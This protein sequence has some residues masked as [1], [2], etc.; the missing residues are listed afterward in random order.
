MP[1]SKSKPRSIGATPPE[2]MKKAVN[3]V[4]EKKALVRSVSEIYAIPFTT[5]W[6]YVKKFSS[7]QNPNN[8]VFEPKYNCRKVFSDVEEVMLKDYLVKASKI[9]Y[10]LSPKSARELAYQYAVKLGKSVLS[11]WTINQCAGEDWLSGFL[12]RFTEL[13]LRKPEATSLARATSFKKHNVS[14]FFDKLEECLKRADYG[15]SDIYNADETGCTTVQSVDNDKVIACRNEKQ[16]GKITSGERG[17][18][19]YHIVCSQCS[20]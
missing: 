17:S 19:I 1:R 11:N 9:H 18:L 16:V 4:T 5:L 8:V 3:E 13:S 20:W 6:R 14:C 15:P 10:G 12:K 2:L 7:S